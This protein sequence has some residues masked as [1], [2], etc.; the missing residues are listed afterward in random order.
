MH[1]GAL[2]PKSWFGPLFH[3]TQTIMK[4]V[5]SSVAT[6]AAAWLA[7]AIGFVP[8]PASALDEP[9]G[10]LT[11]SEALAL[12]LIENPEL[13]PFAWRERANEARLLQAKLRPNPELGVEAENLLGTGSFSVPGSRKPR[14]SSAN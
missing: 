14:C 3:G 1:A 11:L 7:M 10:V 12:A 8:D 2:S 5:N 9:T 6:V 13:A 4:R